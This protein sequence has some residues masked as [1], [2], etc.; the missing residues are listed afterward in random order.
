[1]LFPPFAAD[2]APN[3]IIVPDSSRNVRTVVGANNTT[4]TSNNIYYG[5]RPV[6]IINDQEY[7][8]IVH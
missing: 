2:L 3:E 1:M 6:D 8:I 7:Y 5:Q 4:T